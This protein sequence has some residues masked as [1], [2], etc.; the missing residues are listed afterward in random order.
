M[1]PVS[2]EAGSSRRWSG[3]NTSRAACGTIRPTKPI[4]PVTETTAAVSREAS[5]RPMPRAVSTDTPSE[6]AASSPAESRFRSRPSVAS[7]RRPARRS[8]AR[9]PMRPYPSIGTL[10]TSHI[11]TP[12]RR[13]ASTTVWMKRMSDR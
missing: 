6:R 3:P 10:P 1:A 2:A 4:G 7:A 12:S 8:K 5:R 9:K 13:V 11:R